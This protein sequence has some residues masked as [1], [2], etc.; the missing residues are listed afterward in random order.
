[1]ASY[2][3]RD[4]VC[5]CEL[6]GAGSLSLRSPQF[7]FKAYFFPWSGSWAARLLE[8]WLTSRAL[9]SG[10]PRPQ[11]PLDT[12]AAYGTGKSLPLGAAHR[13]CS[14]SL[15]GALAPGL[16]HSPLLVPLLLRSQNEGQEQ[17]AVQR[18]GHGAVAAFPA[19]PPGPAAV[20]GAGPETPGCHRQPA[21]PA[22]HPHLPAADRGKPG[23]VGRDGGCPWGRPPAKCGIS[24]IPTGKDI[25]LSPP[26]IWVELTV[27]AW[28]VPGA[29]L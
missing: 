29:H 22:L 11:G 18:R 21:R 25:S 15:G 12:L 16:T 5:F 6:L 13:R 19:A 8:D 23:S 3:R 20:E 7:L 2:S 27:A 10:K 14:G 26:G 28:R 1:M 9:V 24:A 17:Q 4:F